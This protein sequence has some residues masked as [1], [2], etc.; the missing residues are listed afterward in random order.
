MARCT[1]QSV[2]GD[3]GV[4]VMPRLRGVELARQADRAR[5]RRGE[6]LPSAAELGAQESV[7][8]ADVMGHETPPCETRP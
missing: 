4:E 7:I 5:E 6:D 3:Q 2:A 1:L 8:E